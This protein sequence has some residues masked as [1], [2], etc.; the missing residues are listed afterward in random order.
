V[1]SSSFKFIICVNFHENFEIVFK[2]KYCKVNK[3]S[4]LHIENGTYNKR[5]LP[6]GQNMQVK[7]CSSKLFKVQQNQLL[8]TH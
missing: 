5:K 2:N 7:S 3:E 4:N 8:I 6:K 1:D